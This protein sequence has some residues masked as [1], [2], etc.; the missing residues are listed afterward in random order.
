M[1]NNKILI[2]VMICLLLAA[3]LYYI[4]DTLFPVIAS[5][6]LFYILNPLATL[7]SKKKK[8]W[9]GVN[10]HIAILFSFTVTA[11]IVYLFFRFLIPPLANEFKVFV[12]NL[13]VYLATTQKILNNFQGWYTGYDLPNTVNGMI[14]SGIKNLINTIVSLGNSF[15][16]SILSMAG[17]LLKIIIIPI[18]TYYLLKDKEKLKAGLLELL[19][20]NHGQEKFRKIIGKINESLNN[21]VKAMFLLCVIVGSCAGLGLHF[22]GVKYAG[23]LGLIAGI[24]EAIPIIGPWVGAV[25][26][27]MVALIYDPVLALKVALL[28][29]VIQL[30]ENSLLVPKVLGGYLNI[31]PIAII[32][33]IL[34]LGKI[35]GPW[36]LFFASPL[37]AII[38]IV[39]HELRS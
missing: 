7:L 16:K 5:F 13:P 17:Q 11:G 26:A 9:P 14:G 29:F 34:V 8:N 18:F 2:R 30:L 20:K 25:P 28:F 23:I 31:H 33:G 10:I 24:T 39:Y 15:I 6:I 3:F 19:P 35:L 36:G 1:I 27:V 32:I 22:L 12:R 4:R 38:N 37:L 21:Y